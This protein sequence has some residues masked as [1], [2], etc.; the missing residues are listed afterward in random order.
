M[1]LQELY[2][3][4][5]GD[6]QA[7]L[8]VMMMDKL[9]ARM[10]V[11]LPADGSAARLL[12][13]GERM[14]ATELFEGAHAL[15]GISASL[16]LRKLSDLAAGICEEFRP[17]N[18]RALSDAEVRVKLEEIRALYDKTVSAIREYEGQ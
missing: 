2:D 5:E 13:A 16:G 12:A 7:A 15:K 18:P 6:Y 11:K 8:K 14:D 10:I 3:R 4:M 17:G 1:T 9:V